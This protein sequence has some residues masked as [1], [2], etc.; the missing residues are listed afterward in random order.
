MSA[1]SA[2]APPQVHLRTVP[3]DIARQVILTRRPDQA[4]QIATMI[5]G[6]REVA[7]GRGFVTYTGEFAGRPVSVLS[8]GLGGPSVSIAIE[9]AIAVGAQTLVMIETALAS[10]DGA[11]LPLVVTSAVR[12]DGTSDEYFPPGL[13]AVADVPL[14]IATR[15]IATRAGLMVELGQVH[16]VDRLYGP[17]DESSVPREMSAGLL[18]PLASSRRCR[19][20]VIV[21]PGSLEDFAGGLNPERLDTL[22]RLALGVLSAES[23]P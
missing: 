22:A 16:S 23:R 19:A 20:L 3:G 12:H 21:Q 5:D 6:A 13:P 15:D 10:S 18:Y 4:A 11:D 14:V 1:A 9:E 17:S 7:R 8:T 2:T